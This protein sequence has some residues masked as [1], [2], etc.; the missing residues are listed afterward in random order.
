MIL[1][2]PEGGVMI[3]D[4]LEQLVKGSEGSWF[5]ENDLGGLSRASQ[6]TLQETSDPAWNGSLMSIYET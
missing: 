2:D 5:E 4:V 1:S 3:L 6:R